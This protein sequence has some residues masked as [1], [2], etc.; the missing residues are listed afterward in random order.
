MKRIFR[1]I[2]YFLTAS[3]VIG[4][5]FF[6]IA[7]A[8]A[9]IYKILQAPFYDPSESSCDPLGGTAGEG[10]DQSNSVWQSSLQPP[11]ILE[12]F[13]IETLKAVAQKRGVPETIAV[14]QEHVISLVAFMIGEGGDINNSQLFNPLNTGLY[15]PELIDGKPAADGVQ[16][17][18]SFDA[19]VEATART[20]VGSSQSRLADVLIR[21]NSTAKQFMY[22]LTYFERFPGNKFWAA[23]SLPPN[24]SSYFQERLILVN[25]VQNN[26]A[27]LAGLVIGTPAEEADIPLTEKSKLQFQGGGG[28]DESD[29]IQG[30]TES[31]VVASNIAT[32]AINLSWSENRGLEA[33]PEYFEA[34]KTYNNVGNGVDCGVFVATVMKATGADPNYPSSGTSAQEEYVRSHPEKYEIAESVSSTADLL[35][36]DI[37]IVN[38]GGGTGAS[39]HTYLFVGLQS[40]G[41]DEASA[42]LNTRMPSLGKAELVDSRGTYIRARLK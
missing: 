24:T 9:N 8:Q 30:C 39:G 3:I 17:F 42:S 32:T 15:A 16:S 36:G 26:Y 25:Q 20:I 14:T 38:L 21:P 27:D 11:Y 40:N 33:K 23:A 34:L 4:S 35:P 7:Q 28:S 18:K 31:G 13:A 29:P 41:T 19:G 10:I 5:V 12:Q 6:P 2:R 22:A 1:H 37:M